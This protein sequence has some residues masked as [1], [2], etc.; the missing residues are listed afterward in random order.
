MA[1]VE[2]FR[3]VV[4]RRFNVSLWREVDRLNWVILILHVFVLDPWI[5]DRP[6]AN[7]ERRAPSRAL[8]EDHRS[9]GVN[10]HVYDPSLTSMGD[11]RHLNSV[12]H[13]VNGVNGRE[14]VALHRVPSVK[15]PVVLLHVSVRVVVTHP[16]RVADRVI[17]RRSLRNGK[18]QKVFAEENGNRVAT[19]LRRR[20]LR[21]EIFLSVARDL[22]A[23]IRKGFTY[24]EY[25]RAR[26]RPNGREYVINGV[27]FLRIL[28]VHRRHV[29]GNLFTRKA[30]IQVLV[31]N[32]CVNGRDG[33]V[34][35]FCPSAITNVFRHAVVDLRRRATLRVRAAHARVQKGHLSVVGGRSIFYPC[36][37]L[38][39]RLRIRLRER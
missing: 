14:N 37:N 20:D 24:Q 32:T 36:V 1:N 38:N 30:R 26:V 17:V 33:N 3:R 12:L 34:H 23:F 29:L 28:R 6:Q 9:P 25:P 31:V 11:L 39:C 19:M 8:K 2:V 16:T 27:F 4:G 35:P 7:R 13:R 15:R 5:H 18:R 22:P 21:D 10:G